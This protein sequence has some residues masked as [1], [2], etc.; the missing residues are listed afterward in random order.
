MD[1]FDFVVLVSS[2]TNGITDIP[3]TVSSVGS[4]PVS[5]LALH[6]SVNAIVGPIAEMESV[7][8]RK[9]AAR[10]SAGQGAACLRVRERSSARG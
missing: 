6:D 8:I 1:F 9:A 2:L 7:S 5:D 10:L 3:P 4:L